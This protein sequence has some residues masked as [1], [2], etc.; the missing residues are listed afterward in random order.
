MYAP[1]KATTATS[2]VAGIVA[3]TGGLLGVALGL[4]PLVGALVGCLAR[5]EPQGD[6]KVVMAERSAVEKGEAEVARR[7]FDAHYRAKLLRS[8]I[9]PSATRWRGGGR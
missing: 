8:A 5:D 7:D 4:V 1:F 3:M 6:Y 9:G 2:A